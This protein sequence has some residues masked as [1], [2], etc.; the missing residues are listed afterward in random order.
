M[1]SLLQIVNEV[2]EG[3]GDNVKGKVSKD[4]RNTFQDLAK[5]ESDCSS[6]KRG[7]DLGFFEKG[8]M[9]VRR[10][11]TTNIQQKRQTNAT[12]SLYNVVAG[13]RVLCSLLANT[14]CNRTTSL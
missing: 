2:L 11:T 4:V 9:Q 12:S 1:S 13:G 5:E 3:D 6:A 8:K 14:F 10:T 7:G